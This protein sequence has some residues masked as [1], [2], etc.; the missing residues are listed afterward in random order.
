MKIRTIEVGPYA[1]NCNIV[2]GEEKKAIVIDPGYDVDLIAEYLEDNDLSVA[3]Y[4]QTH[5][6]A[7]HIH[8][9]VLMQERYPAPIMMHEK[10]AAW[11]FES[12]NSLAPHYGVPGRPEKIEYLIKGYEDVD[13]SIAGLNFRI[14]CTPGH[15]PG[16]ICVYF[17]KE[18]ALFSGDTLFRES[19]GRTDFPGGDS[20]VLAESLQKL[21]ALPDNTFVFCGHG[22]HTNIKHEREHNFFLNR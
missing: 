15:S 9:L 19:V 21:V 6:H 1:V 8:D 4:I 2:W 12:Q 10:D 14:I 20:R 18:G 17:E 7:D 13:F 22:P 5:G 3:L 11:A 16:G